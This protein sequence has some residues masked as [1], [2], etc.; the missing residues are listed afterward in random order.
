MIE[1]IRQDFQNNKRLF[2]AK[3]HQLAA[4]LGKNT[5]IEHVGSTAIPEMSGKNIIDI[6]VAAGSVA[7]LK[8]F[9]EK[10]Q[11]AGFFAG[12]NSRSNYIFLASKQEETAS[13][14]THVHL[15]IKNTPIY[16]DFIVLRQY[17]LRNPTVAKEYSNTKEVFA[18]VANF[19]RGDYKK[20]KSKYV[21]ESLTRAR[22]EL[23]DGAK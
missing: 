9:S 4:L 2:N 10:L 12:K 19:S 16:D 11:S 23:R 21:D 6:L 17:L 3:K 20:L 18:K 14:D 22:K 15:A 8:N 5:I 13:G 1:I 7:E